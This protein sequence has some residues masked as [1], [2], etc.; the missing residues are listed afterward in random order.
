MTSVILADAGPLVALFNR[1]DTFHDWALARF[2]E[3]SEPLATA[4]PVMTESLHLLRRVPGGVEKLLTLW[5]RGQLFVSFSAESEKKA[6]SSLIKRY[7][8]V[9][10]SLADACL[11]R[12]SEIHSRSSV[13]TLDTDFGIY[14]RNG[15]QTIS[16]ISPT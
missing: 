6:L 2:R 10:A 12:L 11:I 8:D 1:N 7:A 4:E 14:R 15:R 3:F 16:V 5:E 13:W 9:P